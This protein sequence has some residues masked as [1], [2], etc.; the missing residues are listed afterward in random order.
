MA[1]NAMI[2]LSDLMD[3]LFLV[4]ST[5]ADVSLFLFKKLK[6]KR[7]QLGT[8]QDFCIENDVLLSK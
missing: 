8:E 6:E 1:Q 5:S 3:S 2:S 7:L 4:R